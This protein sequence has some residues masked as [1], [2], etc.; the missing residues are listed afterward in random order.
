MELDE[1]CADCGNPK[2][3]CVCEIEKE[4]QEEK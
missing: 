1:T 4:E 2:S 3:E